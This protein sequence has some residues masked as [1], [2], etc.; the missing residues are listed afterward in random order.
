MRS[1]SLAT[2]REIRADGRIESLAHP[3]RDCM[4]FYIGATAASGDASAYHVGT[5]LINNRLQLVVL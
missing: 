2:S 1:A 4:R 5:C 3:R